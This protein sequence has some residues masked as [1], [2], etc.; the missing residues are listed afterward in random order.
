MYIVILEYWG[1]E[2]TRLWYLDAANYSLKSLAHG[3][4]KRLQKTNTL[5]EKRRAYRK[6]FVA[7]KRVAHSKR[8]PGLFSKDVQK[9][10]WSYAYYLA[11]KFGYDL[12]ELENDWVAIIQG[13]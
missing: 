4:V 2:S 3:L 7:Y 9:Y 1:Y 5:G 6:Y 8:Y 13:D 10:I 12:Q 11:H